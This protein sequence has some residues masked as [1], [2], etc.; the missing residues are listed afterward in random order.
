VKALLASGAAIIAAACGGASP[1]LPSPPASA[2]GTTPSPAVPASPPGAD[3]SSGSAVAVGSCSGGALWLGPATEYPLDG[4]TGDLVVGDINN[5]G[6]ADL[7]VGGTDANGLGEVGVMFGLGDGRLG[8]PVWNE[9]LPGDTA[10]S[11]TVTDFD[12]DN[13]LDI[14]TTGGSGAPELFLNNSDGTFGVSKPLPGSTHREPPRVVRGGHLGGDHGAVAEN[15]AGALTAWFHVENTFVPDDIASV[16]AALH[17][18]TGLAI[19]DFDRDGVADIAVAGSVAGVPVIAIVHGSAGRRFAPPIYARGAAAVAGQPT[20][21]VAGDFDGNGRLDV[22]V[23]YATDGAGTIVTALAQ[24]NGSYSVA[25]RA[26]V[27]DLAEA[28]AFVA[29]D[30]DNDGKADLVVGTAH[31][32]AVYRASATGFSAP[33][34]LPGAGVHAAAVADLRGDHLLAPIAATG[35][36]VVV[37][38]AAC[39]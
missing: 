39:R 17:D 16:N 35:R 4:S 28:A 24:P 6:N 5:D 30:L 2:P 19:A 23:L 12:D 8:T 21:I 36:A 13:D 10:K 38:T 20:A 7:T 9:M 27:V 18:T 3:A 25:A 32:L 29:G 15:A 34:V 31:G 37:W 11:L 22:A 14:I 26:A 1:P 33:V